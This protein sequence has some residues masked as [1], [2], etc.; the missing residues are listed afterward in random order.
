MSGDSP[1]DWEVLFD[2]TSTSAWREVGAAEFPA[3]VWIV[4]DGCL[5]L[6]PNTSDGK[7]LISLNRY[8]DFE[9]RFEWKISKGGNSGIKYQVHEGDYDPDRARIRSVSAVMAGSCLFICAVLFLVASKKHGRH[10][11]ATLGGIV[12]GLG[13]LSI[14]VLLRF[15]QPVGNAIGLEFQL[16]DDWELRPPSKS[17]SSGALY[18]LIAPEENVVNPP[19]VSNSGR[20][21][22]EGIHVEHWINGTRILEYQLDSPFLEKRIA[23]SKFSQN[24]HF[25][26]KAVGHISL[27]NHGDAVWFRDIRIRPL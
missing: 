23:E 2:G 26:K 3:D 5:T 25:G 16:H 20:I 22:V 27:Q 1:D 6:L 11:P 21:I 24:P 14:Y 13:I 10:W 17:Y 9:L 15:S 4:E 18:D 19:G 8:E 7:D 12:L